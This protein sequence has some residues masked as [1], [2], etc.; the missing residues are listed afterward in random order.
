MVQ[1]V[2]TA[3]E[4]QL[5]AVQQEEEATHQRIEDHIDELLYEDFVAS[6]P[7][8][9]EYKID[10]EEERQWIHKQWADQENNDRDLLPDEVNSDFWESHSAH[11]A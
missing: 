9:V 5:R 3:E 1:E 6:G 11:S 10:S 4:E 8:V 2:T 7:L